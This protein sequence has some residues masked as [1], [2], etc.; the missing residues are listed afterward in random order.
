MSSQ[1]T[2]TSSRQ[3]LT[4]SASTPDCEEIPTRIGGWRTLTRTAPS[5]TLDERLVRAAR[6][7]TDDMHDNDFLS[8]T[9]SNGSQPDE[10]IADTGYV[11]TWWGENIALP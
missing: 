2:Q 9:G 4:C 8:H 11:A 6:A 1:S 7:H 3:P 10:R 5:R